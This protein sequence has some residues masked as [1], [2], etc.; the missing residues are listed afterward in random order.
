MSRW[1]RDIIKDRVVTW[2]IAG[3]YATPDA[4]A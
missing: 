1:T 2:A 3:Y 4:A